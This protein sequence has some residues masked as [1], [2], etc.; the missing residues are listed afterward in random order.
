MKAQRSWDR[1]QASADAVDAGVLTL[2]DAVGGALSLASVEDMCRRDEMRA[3][4]AVAQHLGFIPT[5]DAVV[6]AEVA[7]DNGADPVQAMA[8]ACGVVARPVTLPP[9]WFHKN[10]A[11]AVV[12]LASGSGRQTTAAIAW[13]RRW[14]FIGGNSSRPVTESDAAMISREATELVPRLPDHPVTLGDL[15]RFCLRGTRREWV[16]LA[17]A[18]AIVGLVAFLTPLLIGRIGSAVSVGSSANSLIGL[19]LALV[20][21]AT[22]LVFWRAI[23]TAAVSRIRTRI[24]ARA[25]AGLWDRCIRLPMRWHRETAT[26]IRVKTVTAPDGAAAAISDDVVAQLLDAVVILGSIGAI[27]TTTTP[28]L[29]GIL[30]SLFVEALILWLLVRDA[31]RRATDLSRTRGIATSQIGEALAQIAELR[32]WGGEA[33][34]LREWA[35]VQAP[36]SVIDQQTRRKTMQLTVLS[37]VWPVVTLAVL[38]ALSAIGSTSFSEFITAQTAGVA[39]TLTLATVM[40]AVNAWRIGRA[41]MHSTRSVLMMS[42][43]S[44]DRSPGTLSGGLEACGVTYQIDDDTILDD[45]SFEVSPGEFVVIVGAT[46][47]GKSTLVRCLLGL[48]PPTTGTVLLDDR[49]LALLDG[50]AVRCQIGAALQLQGTPLLPTTIRDNVAMGRRLPADRLWQALD[51]AHVGDD[52]RAMSLGLDTPMTNEGLTLSTGQRQQILVARALVDEPKMLFFDAVLSALDADT[53]N[54]VLGTLRHVQATRVVVSHHPAVARAADRVILMS[55]GRVADSGT[56]GELS[57]RSAQYRA[58]MGLSD[59]PDGPSP[60]AP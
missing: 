59:G 44:T 9:D 55:S 42:P 54:H 56:H 50:D 38:V 60:D 57:S 24:E 52:V 35:K 30:A 37:A 33:F 49:D 46:G 7:V 8:T 13:R 40:S 25:F 5:T 12:T 34:A 32:I 15:R 23:R 22:A 31:G 47:S 28:L 21:L 29:M 1:D 51:A 2:T 36:A 4:A 6:D 39:A 41:R 11:P 20:L 17:G 26:S 27:A 3:V 43:E 14:R 10:S 16:T 48:D 45:V 18:T 53:L 58:L 19:F